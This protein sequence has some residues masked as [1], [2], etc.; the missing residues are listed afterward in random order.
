MTIS[1]AGLCQ[2]SSLSAGLFFF[3]SLVFFA[4]VVPAGRAQVTH[5]QVAEASDLN[6]LGGLSAAAMTNDSGP[7]GIIPVAKGFNVSMGTT[8]QHDSSSGWSSLLTPNVAYR[9][10]QY[11]SVDAGVPMY[12]YINIDANVGTKTKPVYVYS[13]KKGAFGDTSLSFHGDASALTVDYNGTVSL[14]LPSGNTDYG[15]GAGQV[16]YN[17]NNHFER[18]FDLFTPNIEFGFGDTSALVNQR[19]LKSYVA[20]GPMAHFQAG[21][22]VNLPLRMSFEADAYEELPL[23][24]NLVYSTTGSGKKQV[25]T[26]TNK[27]PAE[28]NGF[29]TSLDV[30]LSRHVTMSWFY[31]RS[32]R[33]HDDVGGFSFTFLLKAP[34]QPPEIPF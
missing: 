10:N 14:G 27:D 16:T 23:D 25:T 21:T 11:I 28:D 30:P 31:S 12:M 15:L 20:V 1:R 29:I 4:A 17:I 13:P 18:N 2:F 24:K 34:P 6:E 7:A 3:A 5:E 26:A 8:S 22:A 33:D 9:L 19:V 32:L